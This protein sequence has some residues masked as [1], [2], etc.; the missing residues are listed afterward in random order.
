MVINKKENMFFTTFILLFLILSTF[1][2]SVHS[3]I[4]NDMYRA[5]YSAFGLTPRILQDAIDNLK[6]TVPYE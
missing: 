1:F 6:H 5:E 4:E 2:K 3:L